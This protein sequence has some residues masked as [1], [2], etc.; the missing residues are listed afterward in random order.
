MNLLFL[1]LRRVCGDCTFS[2]ALMQKKR[3]QK[4]KIKAGIRPA[5]PAS[6]VAKVQKLATLRQ[7]ALL[8][9]PELASASRRSDK[10][11]R[12]LLYS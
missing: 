3:Y 10:A 7:S 4:E 5:S 2:F 6:S 9:A 11:Q 8:H 12:E 1:L